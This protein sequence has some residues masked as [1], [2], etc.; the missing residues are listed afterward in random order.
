M[1]PYFNNKP[2]DTQIV[3]TC[4]RCESEFFIKL[5]KKIDNPRVVCPKC[6]IENIFRIVWKESP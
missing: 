6:K 3:V 5:R 2:L 1:K 4:G